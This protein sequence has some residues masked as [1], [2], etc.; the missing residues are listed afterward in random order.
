LPPQPSLIQK[1]ALNLLPEGR[2]EKAGGE[3]VL[4]C[5][6]SKNSGNEPRFERKNDETQVISPKL[7]RRKKGNKEKML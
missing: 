7:E 2:D 5:E 4:D 3:S 6:F 1:P